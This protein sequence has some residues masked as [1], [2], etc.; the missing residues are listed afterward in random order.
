MTIEDFQPVQTTPYSL[1]YKLKVYAW[2]LV[3]KTI[4]RIIPNQIRKPRVLLLNMFGADIAKSCFIHRSSNIE[5][6]WNL[7]MKHLSSIG[8]NATLRCADKISI[9]EKCTIGR[10]CYFITG[11]HNIDS[12][13]F[14]QYTKPIVVGSGTWLTT[15]VYVMPGVTIGEF[16]VAYAKALIV[17]D[18]AP[19]SVVG[20]IPS[21]YIKKREI[22]D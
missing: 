10:N 11:S 7:S 16:T 18:V 2:K 5:F 3:N 17:K 15:A 19:Y 4:Y 6:P 22:K 21:K 9:G 8:E 14:E 12:V 13:H 1:K 20:G